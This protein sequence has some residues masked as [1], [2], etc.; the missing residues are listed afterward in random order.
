MSIFGK[1]ASYFTGA[2]G[3]KSP[4]AWFSEF[5]RGRKTASGADVTAETALELSAYYACIRNISEDL[6]KL[7]LHVYRRMKPRGRERQSQHPAYRILHHRANEE[8]SA[9]SV[10]E[11]LLHFSLGWG[12]GYAEIVRNGAGDPV[13]LYPIH[14]ARV[15]KKRTAGGELRYEVRNPNGETA[16][17][18][19]REMFHLHGLGSDAMQGYEMSVLAKE[20][21]GL[22]MEAEAFGA[23]YFGNGT[24]VGGA[25]ELPARWSDDA[26]RRFRESLERRHKGA[27]KAHG[28]LILEEDAKYNPFGIPPDQAQFLETRQFQVEEICRWFRMPPHKVQHLLRSTFSNIESQAIEYV[29]DTLTPWAVRF[30]QE[31]WAKLLDEDPDIYIEHNFSGLLRGDDSKRAIYYRQMFGVGAMSP[32]DIRELE[33]L[34]PV[35]GGDDY[36]IPLNMRRTTETP[37]DAEAKGARPARGVPDAFAPV[38]ADAVSRVLAKESKAVARAKAKPGY[39]EWLGKF[40]QSQGDYLAEAL[41]PAY[42]ASAKIVGANGNAEA[43]AMK[44]AQAVADAYRAALLSGQPTESILRT[45]TERMPC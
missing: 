21:I 41:R 11:T 33:N 23:N 17:L 13:G 31:A 24:V 35:E 6:A 26:R 40:A 3:T 42:L 28:F 5:F 29:V 39:A 30:E 38:V 8:A 44:A 25:I 20:A 2:S 22:G 34:N 4:A 10:R 15:Q 36:F 27:R 37:E 7:P 18:L 16:R 14:P 12:S 32:N 9:V 45:A 1:I 19:P 43:D